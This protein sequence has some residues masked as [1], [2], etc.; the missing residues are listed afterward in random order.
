MKEIPVIG[1]CYNHYNDGKIRPSRHSVVKIIDVVPYS[2]VDKDLRDSI[3]REQ[4]SCDWLYAETTDVVVFAEVLTESDIDF[5][6]QFYIRDTKGGWFSIDHK[7]CFD[8]GRL[9]IDHTLTDSLKSDLYNGFYEYTPEQ[10]EK[11]LERFV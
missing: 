8:S 10:I 9:D 6:N 3:E 2:K 5:K 11:F 4:K 1:K 7:N